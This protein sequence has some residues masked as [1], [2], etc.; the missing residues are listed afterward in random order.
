MNKK[1]RSSS[2]RERIY[3]TSYPPVGS[4]S[5]KWKYYTAA[6]GPAVKVLLPKENRYVDSRCGNGVKVGAVARSVRMFR[7]RLAAWVASSI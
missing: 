6:I 2:E 1:L 3:V 5:R 4:Q 7:Q